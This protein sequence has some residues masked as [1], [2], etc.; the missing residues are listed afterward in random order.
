MSFQD[1]IV[2][3][4]SDHFRGNKSLASSTHLESSGSTAG[5]LTADPG[6]PR[7]SI[8]QPNN[9]NHSV[10]DSPPEAFL[11]NDLHHRHRYSVEEEQHGPGTFTSNQNVGSP[12]I[13][14]MHITDENDDTGAE[15][16]SVDT[17]WSESTIVPRRNLGFIQI[18]SLMLNGTIGSGIFITP[19][20][21]LF[22]TRSKPIALVLWA[23]GG[24]YTAL[25]YIS[26]SAME[27]HD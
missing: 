2:P 19:G 20:Y 8:N 17:T 12:K 23:V 26:C 25:K 18:T 5:A 14:T 27:R 3:H 6:S 24:I 11:T 9:S 4:T 21:V 10:Q 7:V 1:K 22:L 16:A 13:Q 15:T